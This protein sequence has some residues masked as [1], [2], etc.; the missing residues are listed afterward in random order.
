MDR[1]E[2][3]RVVAYA[4][5]L[6]VHVERD[7]P[8]DEDDLVTVPTVLLDAFEDAQCAAYNAGEALVGYAEGVDPSRRE[9]PANPELEG[10]VF[11]DPRRCWNPVLHQPHSMWWDVEGRTGVSVCRGDG[12]IAARALGVAATSAVARCMRIAEL[13]EPCPNPNVAAG[14]MACEHG[15]WPCKLTLAAALARGVGKAEEMTRLM[16]EHPA[17]CAGCGELL[18]AAGITKGERFCSAACAEGENPS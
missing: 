1:M 9:S 14:V 7:A 3:A 5:T 15:P 13:I 10:A 4:E 2:T 18:S 8:E 11:G 12:R 16:R 17:R 6:A